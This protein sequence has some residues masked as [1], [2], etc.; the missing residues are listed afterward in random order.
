MTEEPPRMFRLP[1]DPPEPLPAVRG[2]E[3]IVGLH[4]R[5]ALRDAKTP[6]DASL[7]QRVRSRAQG[8]AARLTGADDR[9]LA[10]LVRAVDAVAARC[11]ELSERVRNVTVTTDDLARSLGEEVTELRAAVD[12]IAR[13][14][15]D[16]PQA[17]SR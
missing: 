12:R 16:R 3:H 4:T 13:P 6:T 14:D 5:W 11:D 15:P 1:T 2:S 10:D 7:A 17:P 9:F 8:V